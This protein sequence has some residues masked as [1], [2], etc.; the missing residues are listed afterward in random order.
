VDIVT[1][2]L[3]GAAG[4]LTIARTRAHARYAAL[5]GAFGAMLPDADIFIRSADDPLLTIEYHRQ[6]SHSFIMAPLGAL[7]VSVLLWLVLRRRITLAQLYWPALLGFVSHIFLDVATSYGV[8]VFW[9]FSDERYSL[10]VVAVV[11]PV[12]TLVLL[13]GVVLALR[14]SPAWRARAAVGLVG[15]YL[16][17][18]WVQQQRVEHTIA[19]AAAARGHAIMR[20]EIKPT[21][22]NLVLWRSVYL[23]G[24][25]FVVDAV[26]VGL[27]TTVYP[28]GAV[29]V[30]R[31][32]DV[33]PPLERGS[34]QAI[35]TERFSRV[36]QGYLARHPHRSEVIGDVR[37]S[38]LPDSVVPL[39]GIEIDPARQHEHVRFF[40]FREFTSADRRRFVSMLRGRA[41]DALE[42]T[43][44]TVALKRWSSVTKVENAHRAAR[45]RKRE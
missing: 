27:E 24:D 14:A 21:I 11:D 3:L 1:H 38:M 9:P 37:Y 41:P 40:T 28:G 16:A 42:P 15:L 12:V 2:A 6:F 20:H 30:L 45:T 5:A 31:P 43:P 44:A 29:P 7:L 18:G 10:A 26:R 17:F 32:V 33:V 19:Q 22:G 13:T 39:W 34:V 36:S 35:D 8:Q 4:G 25:T 23:T